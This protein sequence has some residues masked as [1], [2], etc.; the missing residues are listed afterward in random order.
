MT[1]WTTKQVGTALQLTQQRI[2]QLIKSGVLPQPIQGRHNPF[3][4]VP[5]YIGLY[6]PTPGRG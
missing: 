2:S 4:V 5:A 3:T 6:Q 1:S